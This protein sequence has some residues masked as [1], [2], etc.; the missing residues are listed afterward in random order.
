VPWSSIATAAPVRRGTTRSS[1]GPGRSGRERA[2]LLRVQPRA[3]GRCEQRPR[4]PGRLHRRWRTMRRVFAEQGVTNARFMFVS[5]ANG[6]KRAATTRQYVPAW[7]PGDSD[8]D[9]IG[10]DA[11]NEATCRYTTGDGRAWR[12]ERPASWPSR[13]STR[14]SRCGSRVGLGRGPGRRRPQGELDRPGAQLFKTDPPGRGWSASP[15]STRPGPARRAT[16]RSTR[17]RRPSPRSRRWPSTPSTP[18]RR[19]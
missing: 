4:Q 19:P 16:G 17:R 10:V 13:T 18:A 1:A 3:R 9:A 7:Y 6:Y 5:T 11:Y 15:T 8:V 2:G 12:S 14:P